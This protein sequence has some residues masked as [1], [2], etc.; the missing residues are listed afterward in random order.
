MNLKNIV[1]NAKWKLGRHKKKIK[2]AEDFLP[3]RMLGVGKNVG[4]FTSACVIDDSQFGGTETG[5]EVPGEKVYSVPLG[6][7]LPHQCSH[8]VTRN[9]C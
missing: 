6:T 2:L 8:L 7:L 5:G 9:G 1:Q 3:W 4:V